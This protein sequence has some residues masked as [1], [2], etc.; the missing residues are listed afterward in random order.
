MWDEGTYRTW[1]NGKEVIKPSS[2]KFQG[3][4]DEDTTLWQ[5]CR[6]GFFPEQ[7]V[8]SDKLLWP[9]TKAT[10]RVLM[11]VSDKGLY[12]QRFYASIEEASFANLKM[13]H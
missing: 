3:F 6:I 4:I 11:H 5:E 1:V 13:N 9:Y 2:N 7:C 12:S 8:Y 10:Q